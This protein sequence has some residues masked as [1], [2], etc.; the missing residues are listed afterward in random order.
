M[1]GTFIFV[2]GTGIPDAS[3]DE[4]LIRSMLAGN[5]AFDGWNVECP[6]WSLDRW[7]DAAAALPS[8]ARGGDIHAEETGD[9]FQAAV[10]SF[11]E[12]LATELATDIAAEGEFG[13]QG[14]GTDWV[15][16]R[17]TSAIQKRRLVITRAAADF[18]RNVFVYFEDGDA[19]RARVLDCVRKAV[20]T[21]AD[22]V[23]VVGHSLGGVI[24]VDALSRNAHLGADPRRLLLVTAGSQMPLFALLGLV[25][26]FKVEEQR[27][28]FAPW[29]NIY[30]ERDP[31]SFVTDAVFPEYHGSPVDIPITQPRDLP[32]SHAGYFAQPEL[33]DIVASRLHT[34]GWAS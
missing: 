11:G 12:D 30:N 6:A 15:L 3:G 27:R 8:N 9:P 21:S 17:V 10:N 13:T 22:P 20:E 31:L 28:P 23:V 34:L 25:D 19:I 16:A 24:A 18:I 4:K 33:Y 14:I 32:G 26:Q 7:G 29:L 1:A 5:A 2:H